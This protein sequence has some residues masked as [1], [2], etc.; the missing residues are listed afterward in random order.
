MTFFVGGVSEL[1]QSDLDLGRL[2]IERLQLED[3]GPGI[4]VEE[5]HYGAVAVAQRL[6]DVRPD[7]L[8]LVSA[9]R[10]DRP[11]GTVERRRVDAPER[12]PAE[13]QA[14]VGDAVTGY[15]HVDLV[16]DVAAG[17]GVLP[18]RTVTV[19]VEPERT[20]SG[21]GLSPSA[22]AGLEVALDL[23]RV[24]LR[25]APLLRLAADL[26]PLV[27]GDRLEQSA[28][29]D[30]LRQLLGELTHLDRD[31][32][33]GRTF[34]LRDRLRGTLAHDVSS[35]GMDHRDWALWWGLVEELDR[36]EAVESGGY[37]R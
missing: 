21:E 9:V 11:V 37:D 15:V 18:P 31:G 20:S 33:W 17:F 32:R 27:D 36:L 28:S 26:R 2:A 5:V 14:A 6:E 8:V 30:A 3:W 23:V 29:R 25:R 16:I 34:A 24:E 13:L 35:E 22:E 19:E 4:L 10:R 1:F 7:V 12:S